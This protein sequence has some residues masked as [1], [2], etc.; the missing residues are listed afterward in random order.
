MVVK[1]E[2]MIKMHSH[3]P[4]NGVVIEPD[5]VP[6]RVVRVARISPLLSVHNIISLLHSLAV[7]I[8][9]YGDKTNEIINSHSPPQRSS[10][11]ARL[12]ANTSGW[13]GAYRSSAL[14][15]SAGRSS[16]LPPR[17]AG[18]YGGRTSWRLI[19]RTSFNLSYLICLDLE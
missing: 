10:Y 16:E 6:T 18:R 2:K 1:S 13:S 15:R 4:P 17:S 12:G 7:F 14:P 5:L 9:D 11:R 19:L 8:T 3:S